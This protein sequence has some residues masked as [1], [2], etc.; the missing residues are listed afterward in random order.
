M[1]TTTPTIGLKKPE[2]TDPF[3]TQDFADNWDKV[4]DAIADI[5][6][7]IAGL[8]GGGTLDADTLEGH[9]ASY[10]Y[11]P[12]NPPPGGGGGSDSHLVYGWNAS[13]SPSQA[14]ARSTA[15]NFVAK[16]IVV[17]TGGASIMCWIR[18]EYAIPSNAQEAF[19]VQATLDGS[20]TGIIS[21]TLV[22]IA[23]T[24]G[25]WY[26]ENVLMLTMASVSAGN[27]TVGFRVTVGSGTS[28]YHTFR[29]WSANIIAF[30]PGGTF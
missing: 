6:S 20:V 5:Q 2:G 1:S 28:S 27:H 12:G 4:D 19:S 10:F 26:L 14:L 30:T 17:P 7:D 22:P 8:G 9:P 18:T 11:S 24:S 15:Y 23:N 3:L 21:D 29:R 25:A 16:K 13:A